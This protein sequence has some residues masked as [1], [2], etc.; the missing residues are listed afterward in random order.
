MLTL[1]LIAAMV[2]PAVAADSVT[3]VRLSADVT[4]DGRAD[5]VELIAERFE[6]GSEF[7]RSRKIQLT[8]GANGRVSVLDLG[9]KGAGYDGRLW[10]ANLDTNNVPEL[11]VTVAT[12]GSGGIIVPF[13][14]TALGDSGL[15][16]VPVRSPLSSSP[17]VEWKPRDHYQIGFEHDFGAGA[18]A[19]AN[20]EPFKGL[21]SSKGKLVS[22]FQVYVDDVGAVETPAAT[23]GTKGDL[24]TYRQAWAVFHAN[25]IAVVRTTWRWNGLQ[26]APVNLEV[27]P[28]FSASEY[29]EYLKGLDKRNPVKAVD[30]AVSDYMARF[31]LQP[32][33]IRELAFKEFREFHLL[34]ADSLA[35]TDTAAT[36]AG[37]GARIPAQKEYKAGFIL[38]YSGEGMYN[39][40]PDP[41]FYR[42]TFAGMLG[43]EY[44]EF[45]ELDAIEHTKPY[46]MDAAMVVPL[47]EVGA[48]VAAWEHYMRSYP[49]SA[50]ADEARLHYIW[51]LSAFLAGT[52]NTPHA[53]YQT[54][55]V[56][57]S[58]LSA[59][60]EHVRL[61][62]GTA[63]ATAA[64]QA[65]TIYR[66]NAR[67]T[68]AV[69]TRIM[70]LVD[71]AVKASSGPQVRS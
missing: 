60:D 45:L 59:L 46:A 35:T 23:S 13:V 28:V 53:D 51:L 6:P 66:Q 61:Y 14:L 41:D 48:R 7:A 37:T 36:V 32:R 26:L 20:D 11:M 22:E 62:P 44:S 27:L 69:R 70:K 33:A 1:A 63:S 12:G 9:E 3:E 2:V 38:V 18:I 4:G 39:V 47:G 31:A 10:T 58:V 40:V 19:I 65:A 16:H 30:T 15:R 21:Y 54:R 24:I 43:H 64:K 57:A 55:T 42:T 17:K 50:F 52:N 56:S 67:V 25:T 49:N 5:V 29:G 8:N 68:D 71:E 34:L